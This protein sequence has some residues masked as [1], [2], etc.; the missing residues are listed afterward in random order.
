[1]F[2]DD[3]CSGVG[4]LDQIVTLFLVFSGKAILFLTL[5]SHFLPLII[6]CYCYVRNLFTE[7]GINLNGCSEDFFLM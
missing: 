3:I 4:L 1:M 6:C 5:L 2:S 7:E